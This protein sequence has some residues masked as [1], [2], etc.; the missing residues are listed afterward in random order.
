M[1]THVF[2]SWEIIAH[3]NVVWTGDINLDYKIVLVL[4][5]LTIV[6]TKI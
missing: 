6:R 1:S 5:L 3:N 4:L 2:S